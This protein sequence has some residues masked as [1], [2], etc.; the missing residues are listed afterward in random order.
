MHHFH[1]KILFWVWQVLKTPTGDRWFGRVGPPLP[2]PKKKK[3]IVP[4]GKPV[5]MRLWV[6]HKG[7][8]SLI[9]VTLYIEMVS[10]PGVMGCR[11]D[12]SQ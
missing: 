7:P 9:S 6:R 12:P 5:K 10:S 4:P 1:Q 3:S 8:F 2:P 11:I